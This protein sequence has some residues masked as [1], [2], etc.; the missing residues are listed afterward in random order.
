MYVSKVTSFGNQRMMQGY[1][2]D[3]AE[4]SV[5][6]D[7]S[8]FSFSNSEI[9]SN[10]NYVSNNYDS[11]QPYQAHG[12]GHGHYSKPSIP[13]G[14]RF[15]SYASEEESTIFHDAMST[16]PQYQTYSHH[17]PRRDYRDQDQHQQP[18][19]H[20]RYYS[21]GSMASSQYTYGSYVPQDPLDTITSSPKRYHHQPNAGYEYSHTP[22]K[23]STSQGTNNDILLEDAKPFWSRL[24]SLF[25]TTRSGHD[26]T[27]NEG[28]LF[29]SCLDAG[30]SPAATPDKIRSLY[31][32]EE[33]GT[34]RSSSSSSID[35]RVGYDHLEHDGHG[36][37]G[38]NYHNAVTTVK[39]NKSMSSKTNGTQRKDYSLVNL[40]KTPDY[41]K[42]LNRNRQTQNQ[43]QEHNHD[44]DERSDIQSQ[45][46]SESESATYLTAIEHEFNPSNPSDI[47]SPPRKEK[48]Q[49]RLFE[50]PG[51]RWDSDYS[52]DSIQSQGSIM[53]S[54]NRF[55]CITIVVKILCLDV[56][57]IL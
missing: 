20:K 43:Y 37:D 53:V 10:S 28:G 9:T 5:S 2:H 17:S 40:G 24:K 36:N 31:E 45:N 41:R 25:D 4:S 44:H 38:T 3:R 48:S 21:D 1:I 34:T 12:R 13:Q 42:S 30:H 26:Q 14:R 19:Q 33:Y 11:S 47:S 27:C 50:T 8:S 52:P 51:K 46:R 39:K 15:Q 23:H 22:P 16:N 49:R 54:S 56:H 32:V 7:S 18:H 55:M 35:K 6:E 57:L 29:S